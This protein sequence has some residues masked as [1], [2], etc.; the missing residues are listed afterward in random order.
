MSEINLYAQQKGKYAK[1]CYDMT[2]PE[3]RAFLG[4][5]ILMEVTR[6]PRV[7]QFWL[8]SDT[9]G[10]FP[11]ITGAFVCDC[12]FGDLVDLTFQ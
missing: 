4:V 8:K 12:F 5:C 1:T 9:F 7:T 10:V 6:M 11:V 3:L 2:A